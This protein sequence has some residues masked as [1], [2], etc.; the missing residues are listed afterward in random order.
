MPRKPPAGGEFVDAAGRRLHHLDRPGAGVPIVMIHGMPGLAHDF[1]GVADLL[2]GQ[3]LIAFDRPGYG[4]SGGKPASF[5][6]QV[7]AIR[8]AL[9]VLRVDRAIL[10]GHSFGGLIAL[11]LAAA[12]PDLVRGMVLVAP[13]SGGTRVGRSR[14]RQARLIRLIQRPL[15]RQIADLL[16]LRALRK[17]AAEQGA[18]VAYGAGAEGAAA[19][20]RA[21]ALLARH[22]NIA[23]LMNDRIHFNDNEARVWDSL[24]GIVVPAIIVHGAQDTVVSARRGRR[25]AERLP[26][27]EIRVVEGN[28]VLPAHDPSSVADAAMD[29]L[30]RI[31]DK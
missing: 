21:L 9:R 14:I 19:R 31:S 8:A 22:D 24:P 2:E 10:I 11:R 29:M 12:Y 23:A 18:R 20:H 13:A 30:R 6:E 5:E 27:A 15:V 16:F 4:H 26:D 7:E 28:H 25:V 17:F 1:D 3:R